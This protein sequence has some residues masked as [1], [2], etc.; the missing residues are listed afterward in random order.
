M[1]SMVIPVVEINLGVIET[2]SSAIDHDP[3]RKLN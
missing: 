2:W 1:V 3:I